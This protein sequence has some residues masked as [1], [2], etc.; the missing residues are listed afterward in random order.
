MHVTPWAELQQSA[1]V[2]HL[3]PFCEQPWGIE[4]H[5]GAPPS[6]PGAQ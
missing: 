4:R 1:V 6:S 5:T 3:S 2:L